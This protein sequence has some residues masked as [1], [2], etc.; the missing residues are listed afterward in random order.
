[1]GK[2]ERGKGDGSMID[3]IQCSMIERQTDKQDTLAV[4][5]PPVWGFQPWK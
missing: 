5:S 4:I 1:M 2:G 3:N